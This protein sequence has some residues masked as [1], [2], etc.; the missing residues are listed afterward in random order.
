LAI[1]E[2][3]SSLPPRPNESHGSAAP[4]TVPPVQ[5]LS[6]R[7]NTRAQVRDAPQGK[8]HVPDMIGSEAE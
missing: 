3:S 1:P 7:T 8:Q 4:E 5:S 2:L 6:P